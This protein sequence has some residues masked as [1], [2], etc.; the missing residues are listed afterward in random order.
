MI[1]VLP[2]GHCFMCHIDFEE[3]C[4]DHMPLCHEKNIKPT[5]CKPGCSQKFDIPTLIKP[6][7]GLG[8][9]DMPL[10]INEIDE[11]VPGKRTSDV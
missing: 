1:Q 11:F 7:M 10:N 5:M 4:S 3:K 9:S 8:L 2:G 6:W